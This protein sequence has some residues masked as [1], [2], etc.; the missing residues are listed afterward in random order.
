MPAFAAPCRHLSAI[1]ALLAVALSLVVSGSDAQSGSQAPMRYRPPPLSAARLRDFQDHPQEYHRFLE[2]L[3]HRST[4]VSRPTRARVFPGAGGIWQTV[5]P[6]PAGLGVPIL[7]GDGTVVVASFDANFNPTPIWYRLTPDPNGDYAHGSWSQIAPLPVIGGVQYAPLYFASAVLP[8]GRL[9]VMGG[10]YNGSAGVAESNLGAIYD[11]VADSWT[12]V[13]APKGWQEIGDAQS[14]VLD[15]GT[16][17]LGSCCADPAKDALLDAQSLTWTSAKA[18]RAGGVRYQSE[19]GYELLPGGDVLTIDIWT[20]VPGGRPTNAERYNPASGRWLEAGN[21]PV[22]LVDPRACR[23]F[24]IGPAV[25]RGDDTLVA[26]GGNTGCVAGDTL[27][28]TAIFHVAANAW[29]AG[30]TVPA[31]CGAD[32]LTACSLADAP[33]ALLPNGNILFAA[34][35]GFGGMPTHF[36]EFTTANTIEQVADP[37][38]NADV[39]GAYYYNF[40]VLPSGQILATDSS[41]AAEI[42]IPG[43][44]PIASTAPAIASVPHILPAGG[45]YTIS[46]TQFSGISQGAYY[47]DD[48]QT[49][50]NFPIVRLINVASGHVFYARTA[51]VTSM[52]IAP[53]ASASATFTVPADIERGRFHLAVIANGVA[54]APVSVKVR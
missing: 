31:V 9:I 43:G 54:S 23:N 34:S 26:F 36:F 17:L 27:D 12:P 51:N 39:S 41:N 21:T 25:M 40:V 42:Y 32:G 44:K 15:D 48:A 29:S 45:A 10:E 5:T 38:L 3:P 16:F 4:A 22:S 35:A 20:D 2:R 18:P 28:P 37:V 7:L 49:S 6:A 1:C 24:E 13:S 19:Q 46:G 8:D 11:P 52:S 33:A 14:V 47:G 30:P 53:G 50:T